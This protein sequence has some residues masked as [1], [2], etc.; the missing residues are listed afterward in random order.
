MA[1]GRMKNRYRGDKI[2]DGHS[3]QV[4]GLID[5]LEKH[6][7]PLEEVSQIRPGRLA[8]YSSTS[9]HGKPTKWY[10]TADA[11]A[12]GVCPPTNKSHKGRRDGG[13]SF[14]ATC[15]AVIGSRVT[16]V[17]CVAINGTVKQEVFLLGPDLPALH[18]RLVDLGFAGEF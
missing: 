10:S 6:I 2:V 8:R 15:W 18:S 4:D 13:F 7:S 14:K 12:P 1:K 17:K 3:T 11:P 5:F 16:G 9:G